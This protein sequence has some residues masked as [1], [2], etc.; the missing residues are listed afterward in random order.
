MVVRGA[1]VDEGP[2]RI[3]KGEG[4]VVLKS[5][6]RPAPVEAAAGGDE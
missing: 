6:I 3:V 1:I 4:P 5:Q 2:P